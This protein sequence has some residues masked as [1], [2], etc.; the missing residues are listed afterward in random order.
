VTTTPD[1]PAH[2]WTATDNRSPLSCE[3]AQARIT[4]ALLRD[5]EV[6]AAELLNHLTTT[7]YTRPHRDHATARSNHA[8]AYVTITAGHPSTT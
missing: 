7:A 1:K 4:R 6:A 5:E 3:D 2:Q 8:L